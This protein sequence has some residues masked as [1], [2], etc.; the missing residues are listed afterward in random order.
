MN[1]EALARAI[2]DAVPVVRGE[3]LQARHLALV[4]A[5]NGK[6]GATITEL[7][8]VLGFAQSST[9]ELVDSAEQLELVERTKAEHDGRL[10]VVRLTP[11]GRRVLARR[12]G[13]PDD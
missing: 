13:Q 2:L 12:R 6:D 9:S 1:D 11:K 10:T 3:L 7:R 8:D 5:L 4:L